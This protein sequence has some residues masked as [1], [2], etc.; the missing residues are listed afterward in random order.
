[1]IIIKLFAQCACSFIH[2]KPFGFYPKSFQTPRFLGLET[3]ASEWLPLLFL[4]K[5]STGVLL[6]DP[7]NPWTFHRAWRQRFIFRI[8]PPSNGAEKCGF[9]FLLTPQHTQSNPGAIFFPIQASRGIAGKSCGDA[10]KQRVC[11]GLRAPNDVHHEMIT[12]PQMCKWR[13][14]SRDPG[15]PQGTG[16]DGKVPTELTALDFPELTLCLLHCANL[17][18]SPRRVRLQKGRGG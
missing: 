9:G 1:M 7:E 15:C 5:N 11:P 14:F 8:L 12:R 16:G 2:L 17:L 18:I 4:S 10:H 6:G 3:I 13:S